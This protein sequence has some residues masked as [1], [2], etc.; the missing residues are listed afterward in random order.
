MKIV[1]I[2]PPDPRGEA[3]L[4]SHTTPINL[5]YLAAYVIKNGY[6]AEI[7]DFESEKFDKQSFIRRVK[8]AKPTIIG[9]TCLTPTIING[10]KFA[11]LVK[12][13]FPYIVTVTGGH[14]PSAWPKRT[15]GDFPNFDIVVISEGEETLLELCKAVEKG[16]KPKGI[17]GTAYRVNTE[18]KM[19][20]R[21]PLIRDLD[22]LPFPA[23]ELF[24]L[25]VTRKGHISRGMSNRLKNTEIYTSRGCPVGCIFCANQVTMNSFTRFRSPENVLA[26]VKE[27]MEKYHFDH[28]AIADDTFT[29][30]PKR[31]AE[32]CRGLQKLGVKS[33]HCEGTRV[34]AVSLK[35]LKLMAKTGCQKIVFGVESGS[36]RVLKLIGKKISVSQVKK[37]FKWARQAGI[38]YVEGNYII[39]SHPSETREDIEKTIDLIKKTNPDLI[40]A[41]VIVPYPGTKLYDLMKE[42][43]YIFSEDWEKF[44]MFGQKPLWRT[45]YFG[46]EDLLRIQRQ[47][48]KSFYLRVGYILHILKKIRSFEEA[49][50]W[51]EIGLNFLKW[52]IQKRLV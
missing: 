5:G 49:K 39:G 28:F 37:A 15:L 48:L 14:H 22:S 9:F 31:A 42:K 13:N 33:W 24:N 21:R 27:C 26:E 20:P 10:H 44:V 1:L 38:K 2:R 45:D 18:I 25:D 40:S 32:I 36:P 30:N 16:K 23:R 41:S 7:W 46:P 34:S 12:E 11:K 51:G 47:I 29:L 3:S 19:E 50:Y 6:E 52:L 17:L 43:D 4:L 8:K 35:L